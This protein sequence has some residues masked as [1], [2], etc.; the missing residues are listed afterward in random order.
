MYACVN[1]TKHTA[2]STWQEIVIYC[3]AVRILNCIISMFTLPSHEI[4]P[5]V[6][7]AT[8]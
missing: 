2:T 6:M 4:L 5:K 1:N 7:T 3:Q 8:Y